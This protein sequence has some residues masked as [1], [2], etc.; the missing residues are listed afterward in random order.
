M[1]LKKIIPAGIRRIPKMLSPQ[2][3]KM[4]PAKREKRLTELYKRRMG[5]ELDLN[6]PVTFTEKLQWMKLY[7]EN[8]DLSRCVDK[9]EFKNY[10]AEKLGDGY[11]A[12]MLKCWDRPEDVSLDG[13][14]VQFVL[15]S[16][17]QSDGKYIK[18]VKDKSKID[19]AAVVKEIRDNWFKPGNLLINSYCRAYYNVKPRVIAEEYIE[20]FDGQVND[21]KLFCFGG[22]PDLFY[23]A[24]EHF[25]DSKKTSYPISFFTLDWQWLDVRYGAHEPYKNAEKPAHIDE[26]IRLAEK[27]AKDFP[28]VRVDFFDTDE[29][30]YLAE[31][32][33]YPGGGWT[34]YYPESFN[35]EL[36][37]K[38]IL[39]PRNDRK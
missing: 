4:S 15:K 17:C 28:F 3:Q 13:L 32:T 7:Y 27:L 35:K 16:N 8:P 1:N 20:Q 38:L 30:L 5:K 37:D 14:P 26:M 31:L 23:V 9:Y 10:I 22:K 39:P 18:I 33:F 36:G 19:S 24:T 34:A 6:N 21:Y 11:T 2:I 12:K 25:N 29:K